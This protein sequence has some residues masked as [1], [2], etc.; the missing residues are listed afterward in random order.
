MTSDPFGISIPITNGNLGLNIASIQFETFR[1]LDIV[2]LIFKVNGEFTDLRMEVV[3][4]F[5]EL[6]YGDAMEDLSVVNGGDE[7]IGDGVDCIIKAVLCH[8]CCKGCLW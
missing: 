7:T 1:H 6:G 3:A 4:V 8:Q 2:P 5:S